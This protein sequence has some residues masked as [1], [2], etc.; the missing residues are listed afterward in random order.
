MVRLPAAIQSN[1]RGSGLKTV[2]P[3]RSSGLQKNILAAVLR[4]CAL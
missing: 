3:D 4:Q 2:L 1:D